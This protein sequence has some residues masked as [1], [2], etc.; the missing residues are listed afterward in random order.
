MNPHKRAPKRPKREK[1]AWD[2]PKADVLLH[3]MG[4]PADLLAAGK[5]QDNFLFGIMFFLIKAVAF[6]MI[7][8]VMAGGIYGS[9]LNLSFGLLMSVFIQVF[10]VS[11]LV[12]LLLC[13]ALF[14][15]GRLMGGSTGF[16]SIIAVIGMTTIPLSLG[17]LLGG[18]ISFFSI[19]FAIVVLCAAFCCFA[20]LGYYGLEA[21]LDVERNK[22]IFAVSILFALALFIFWVCGD[23]IAENFLHW[24]ALLFQ[25]MPY[26]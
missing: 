1:R 24:T 23:V 9:V 21:V 16:K 26:R 18:I 5:K 3:M 19:R 14:G 15:I 25:Q 13:C 20:G 4:K 6:G 17:F 22:K 2:F 11:F 7:F 8:A 12:D 10:F